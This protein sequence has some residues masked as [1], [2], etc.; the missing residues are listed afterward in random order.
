MSTATG[1][2]DIM[3]ASGLYISYVDPKPEQ[4]TVED[5]AHGL[6]F[7]CR[8]SGQCLKYYSVA[9]HS[10]RVAEIVPEEFK[11][12][13]LLHDAAEAYMT[14]MPRPLKRLLPEYTAIEH[15]VLSVIMEKF[16]VPILKLPNCVK[17]ADNIMLATEGRDLCAP[18]WPYWGLDQSPLEARITETLSPPIAEML[19]L[20]KFR[21][22]YKV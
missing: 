12:I 1:T 17:E 6:S 20:E 16:G 21:E 22:Y 4:I 10:I 11:L 19:W 7:T 14:D 9:E 15:A 8:F 3:T 18:A 5:I 2:P 13:A